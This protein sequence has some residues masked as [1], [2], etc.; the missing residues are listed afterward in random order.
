MP[1]NVKRQQA[2]NVMTLKALQSGTLEFPNQEKIAASQ[3]AIDMAAIAYATQDAMD[4]EKMERMASVLGGGGLGA[5]ASIAISKDKPVDHTTY[6][7]E[8][9]MS[10]PDVAKA[11]AELAN[12]S[13]FAS[14][15]TREWKDKAVLYGGYAT[16]S[17]EARKNDHADVLADLP[18]LMIEMMLWLEYISVFSPF[19]NN[20]LL[21]DGA[22]VF[23]STEGNVVAAGYT[24][25][26]YVNLL[27]LGIQRT[28][29]SVGTGVNKRHLA[30]SPVGAVGAPAMWAQLTRDT[31]GMMKPDTTDNASNVVTHGFGGIKNYAMAHFASAGI[32]DRLIVFGDKTKGP[33]GTM[34]RYEGRTTPELYIADQRDAP[35]PGWTANA[36][37]LKIRYGFRYFVNS[38]KNVVA[39]VP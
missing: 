17:E 7:H 9:E 10:V 36:Y 2:A 29:W 19:L 14:V 18:G 37:Q 6:V 28:D 38:R 30:W 1:D 8:V 5:P 21:Q 33:I 26:Q 25:A 24:F 12:Y 15:S 20:S 32:T 11:V 35:G 13:E 27:V 31:S 34:L 16:I 3:A 22:N 23:N 4:I 39:I